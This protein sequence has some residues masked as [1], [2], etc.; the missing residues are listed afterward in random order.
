MQEEGRKGLTEKKRYKCFEVNFCGKQNQEGKEDGK[1]KSRKEVKI[2]LKEEQA[3]YISKLPYYFFPK[4]NLV[5]KPHISSLRCLILE[6]N[7]K[8]SIKQIFC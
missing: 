5:S 4:N 3:A 1:W 2:V 6:H 7:N 8:K